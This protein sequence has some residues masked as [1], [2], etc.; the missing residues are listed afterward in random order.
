ME[1]TENPFSHGLKARPS[2]L[3]TSAFSND[4]TSLH[5]AMEFI[6]L[7]IL[8]ISFIHT[9]GTRNKHIIKLHHVTHT[10]SISAD[11]SLIVK[12]RREI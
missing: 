1:N 5:W 10:H 11:I 4:A 8:C 6:Y 2:S 3:K 9:L 12:S 7:F